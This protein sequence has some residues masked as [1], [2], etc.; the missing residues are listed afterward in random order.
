MAEDAARE[1]PNLPLED[2]LPLVKLYV[3]R[4]SPKYEKGSDAVARA[5]SGRRLAEAPALRGGRSESRW[6]RP[7]GHPAELAVRLDADA[8]A[9]RRA[10]GTLP[11]DRDAPLSAA[12]RATPLPRARALR[13]T[14]RARAGRGALALLRDDRRAG[15]GW[16]GHA[17]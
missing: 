5:V 14:L 12:D 16:S 15:S 17:T 10:R 1:L 11:T 3:E 4:G 13:S 8:P 7:G 6:A 2:A 9:A